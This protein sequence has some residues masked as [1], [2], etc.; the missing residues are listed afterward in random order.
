LDDDKLTLLLASC[1]FKMT[2]RD[3]RMYRVFSS[4]EREPARFILEEPPVPMY[5]RSKGWTKTLSNFIR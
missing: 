3:L 4:G 1:V 5:S 2:R